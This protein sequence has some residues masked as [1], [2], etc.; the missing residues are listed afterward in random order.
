[1]VRSIGHRS[2]V[3]VSI[4]LKLSCC[5]SANCLIKCRGKRYIEQAWEMSCFLGLWFCREVEVDPM[6]IAFGT[7]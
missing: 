4:S 3:R 7:A 1:M 5:S 6:I 2:L